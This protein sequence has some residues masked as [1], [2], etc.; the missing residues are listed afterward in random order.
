MNK[1]KRSNNGGNVLHLTER[2]VPPTR[3]A[4]SL[5]TV[6]CKTLMAMSFCK[7]FWCIRF[8]CASRCCEHVRWNLWLWDSLKDK[9]LFAL[10][11]ELLVV[12]NLRREESIIAPIRGWIA[13][14]G[15][16]SE[17]LCL[18]DVVYGVREQKWR[19]NKVYKN[20]FFSQS[21]LYEENVTV[22]RRDPLYDGVLEQYVNRKR[23]MK[24]RNK[25]KMLKF[26]FRKI[27]TVFGNI[28]LF[29]IFCKSLQSS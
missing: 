6:L 28:N 18:F 1:V 25:L 10:V 17:F 5:L 15:P 21:L 22:L 16:C 27:E 11:C 8:H 24:Q 13:W 23:Y 14:V 4:P 19:L 26:C 20:V 12:G 3:D 29:L 7:N 9:G 2:M